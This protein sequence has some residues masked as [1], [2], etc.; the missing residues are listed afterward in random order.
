MQKYYQ[1][2]PKSNSRN[3]FINNLLKTKGCSVC[4]RSW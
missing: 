3:I 4:N 2:K 1:N